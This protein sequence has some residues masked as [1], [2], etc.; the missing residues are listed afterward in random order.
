MAERFK[1]SPAV[2]FAA[3]ETTAGIGWDAWRERATAQVATVR[4]AGADN[5]IL[6][7]GCD[8]DLS[9]IGTGLEAG[10]QGVAFEVRI[11]LKRAGWQERFLAAA[12]RVPVV[13]WAVGGTP[14]DGAEAYAWASD[15]IA[16]IQAK[17]LHWFAASFDA[18]ATPSLIQDATAFKPTPWWGSFVR[19]ALEG[20]RLTTD[21]VR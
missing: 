13:V 20:A 5:L 14:A 21:R 1:N 12:D 18:N 6:I 16:C 11:D 17:R 7:G 10:G 8:G 4:G 2:I 3:G 19:I 9:G 15:C